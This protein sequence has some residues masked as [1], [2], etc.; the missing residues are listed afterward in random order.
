MPTYSIR[1]WHGASHSLF[2]V[3][4]TYPE[5]WGILASFRSRELAEKYIK[6]LEA[7]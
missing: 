5:D 3:I 4:A 7:K 6:Q 1:V 2:Y